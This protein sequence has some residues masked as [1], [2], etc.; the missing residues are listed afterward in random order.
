[1]ALF[2]NAIPIILKHEGGLTTDTGGLTKYGISQKAYPGLDIKNL[3]EADAKKIYL[4]DYWN[5]LKLDGF[6]DQNLANAVFD[7]GI[8][9]GIKT[10]AKML[11]IALLRAKENLVV[12]GIIGPLTTG[13]ANRMPA[14]FVNDFSNDRVQFYKDL[15]TAN[16][17]KYGR[18]LNGWIKRAQ[19]YMV[20][21]KT[22]IALVAGVAGAVAGVIYLAKKK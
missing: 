20:K 11:Q 22:S 3:T 7:A 4:R 14:H 16:P 2:N 19:S 12:D 9:Q 1:M 18:Y 8:N 17:E 5:P 15:A 13:A 21:K 6:K 10:A